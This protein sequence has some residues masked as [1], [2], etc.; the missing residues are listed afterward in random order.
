MSLHL[1]VYGALVA[2][3]SSEELFF[4]ACLGSV[5]IGISVVDIRRF[6]VPDTFSLILAGL[7]LF[8]LFYHPGVSWSDHLVA[9]FGF[10][11]VLYAVAEIYFRM[12]GR[13]GL[14]FGDVK[15]VFG[16]GLLLGVEGSIWALLLASVSGAAT[17]IAFAAWHRLPVDHLPASGLAFA[18]FLCLSSW[19]VFL[20]ERAAW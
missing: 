1:F 20:Q 12:K 19:A 4:C 14:G 13:D 7:G 8:H 15:L 10:S 3:Y 16:L 6:E 9:G 5:L 17:L 11:F 2:L 18:P